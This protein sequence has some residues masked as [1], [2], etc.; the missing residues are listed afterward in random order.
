MHRVDVLWQVVYLLY[1]T[2]NGY[3]DNHVASEPQK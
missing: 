2:N 3:H 1:Y